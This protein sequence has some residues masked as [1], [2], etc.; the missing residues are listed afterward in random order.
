MY[1][2]V[3]TGG[4]QFRVSEGDRFRVEKLDQTVGSSV[5]L[6]KVLMLGNVDTIKI[7]TPE[8]KDV[9]VTCEVLEQGRADKILVFKKKRR[10][11]YQRTY[12]HRQP[13]TLLK[14]TSINATGVTS[15]AKVEAKPAVK[16]TTKKAV[17][18]K[19]TKEIVVKKA[20]KKG[21]VQK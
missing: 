15:K 8:V 20:S 18:S 7:G 19:G 3:K 14:V 9:S 1:A 13:F 6:D 5:R 4:R 2:V 12:G 11:R 10:K 21:A 17:S 16:R